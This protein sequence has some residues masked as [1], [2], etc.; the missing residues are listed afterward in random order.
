MSSTGTTLQTPAPRLAPGTATPEPAAGGD[1][2]PLLLVTP[3]LVVL[4]V[5]FFAPN[6]TIFVLSF[7]E[8]REALIIPGFTLEHYQKALA[9]DYYRT[10]LLRT[11]Q[12]SVGV[13]VLTVVL[14]YPVAYFLV[15]SRSRWKGVVLM[16]VLLPLLASVVV[17]T[18]GWLV[19]LQDNGLV[20]QTLV[21][22]GLPRAKLIHNYTAV[23]IGMT[24]VLLPYSILSIMA[25]LQS[26]H[27]SL[28]SAAQNLG[29]SRLQTFRRILLPLSMPGMITGFVLTVALTLSAFA[30][31]RILGGRTVQTVATQIY[32]STLFLLNWPFA[33][34]LAVIVL[35]VSL[36]LLYLL[37]RVPERGVAV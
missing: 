13:G 1:K 34:A 15:R 10:I 36:I 14:G 11:L 12:I 22:L 2:T 26:I 23:F 9:D 17:R 18:Y 30:T 25:S 5:L 37:G 21:A 7:F 3:A 29:A 24:H 35:V 32:D 27:P 31:P 20:N 19:L 16:L 6:A 8:Y 4:V 33:S 28:E